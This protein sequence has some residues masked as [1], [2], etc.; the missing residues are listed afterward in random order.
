MANKLTQA[1]R[2]ELKEAFDVFDTDGSGMISASELSNIF[3][4]LNINVNNSQ[5]N[6]LV[7]QMDENGSGQVEFDEFARVMGETFFKQYTQ[8]ELRIAFN[9][10]D[11]DGSGY[12]QAAEL[13]S[14]MS[15]MGRRYN[16]AE[17]EAMVSSLDLS[18]D[19]KIGFDEFVQLFQ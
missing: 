7:K 6:Q 4:A 11:R 2:Q 8:E 5:L 15:R 9:Q 3:R 17:V 13:E 10:F 16:K 18:G 19:G 14:I 1:Q 12:I